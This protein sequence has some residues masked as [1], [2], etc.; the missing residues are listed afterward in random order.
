M[1]KWGIM[2]DLKKNVIVLGVKRYDFTNDKNETVRGTSVWYYDLELT[3]EEN[4][5]GMLPNKATLPYEAFDVEK[6]HKFPCEAVALL[7]LD[8]SKGKIKVG[9]F[10]F[11]NK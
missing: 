7:K 2:M 11:N 1:K 4:A 8:L 9:G 6:H 10:Q 5:V 3:N